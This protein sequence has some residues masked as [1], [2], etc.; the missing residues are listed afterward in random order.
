MRNAARYLGLFLLVGTIFI[1][2]TVS[3]T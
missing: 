2:L 1:G 3:L